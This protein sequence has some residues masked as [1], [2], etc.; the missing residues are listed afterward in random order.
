MFLAL[1][2]GYCALH[3]ALAFWNWLYIYGLGHLGGRLAYEKYLGILHLAWRFLTA[4]I[5][6]TL[7]VRIT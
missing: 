1:G 2:T 4:N 6:L 5:Y 3:S 7:G